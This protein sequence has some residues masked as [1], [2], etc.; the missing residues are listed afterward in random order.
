MKIA[1]ILILISQ[2]CIILALCGLIVVIKE[3]VKVVNE[4][5]IRIF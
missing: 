5:M 1:I 3:M 2:F 4:C